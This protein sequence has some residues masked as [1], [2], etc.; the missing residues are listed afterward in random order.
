MLSSFQRAGATTLRASGLSTCRSLCGSV[1]WM[2]DARL[3]PDRV[4]SGKKGHSLQVHC[5]EGH[6]FVRWD[7]KPLAM[8]SEAHDRRLAL[9]MVNAFCRGGT[10]VRQA[11]VS[12]SCCLVSDVE[13]PRTPVELKTCHSSFHLSSNVRSVMNYRAVSVM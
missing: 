5:P 9:T 7:V 11:F 12:M 6:S 10:A 13:Q 1:L 3:P 4:T 2:A 8:L